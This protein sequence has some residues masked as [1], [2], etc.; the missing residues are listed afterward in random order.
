MAAR[1]RHP[2][3]IARL[4]DGDN[5]GWQPYHLEMMLAGTPIP[6]PPRSAIYNPITK[7]T[8]SSR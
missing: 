1:P 7:G 3:A 4:N 5:G 8:T 6:V 2:S